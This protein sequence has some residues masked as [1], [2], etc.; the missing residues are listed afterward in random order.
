MMSHLTVAEELSLAAIRKQLAD[1]TGLEKV[2]LAGRMRSAMLRLA[3]RFPV[4]IQAPSRGLGSPYQAVGWF[5]VPE[6]QDHETTRRQWREVRVEFSDTIDSFP[7][8]LADQGI[9]RH[10]V[11]G[12]LSLAQALRFLEDHVDHHERQID[13]MVRAG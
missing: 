7:P 10:P 2:G 9:F 1:R 4:R 6:H 5:A 3:M 13:R 8:E 11:M 12:T